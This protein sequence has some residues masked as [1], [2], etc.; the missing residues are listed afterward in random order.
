MDR[1]TKIVHCLFAFESDQS[2]VNQL[3]LQEYYW[4]N[5]ELRKK[6]T[7]GFSGEDGGLFKLFNVWIVGPT[8]C[9][10]VG[11]FLEISSHLVQLLIILIFH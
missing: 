6:I 4:N 11:V 8:N 2:A 1:H 10:K 7:R 3:L 9:V 5:A